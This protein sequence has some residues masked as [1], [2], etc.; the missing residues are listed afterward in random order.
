MKTNPRTLKTASSVILTAVA[1][2][3]VADGHG[4]DVLDNIK[5]AIMDAIVKEFKSRR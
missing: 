2:A 5:P 1:A 3:F 4:V